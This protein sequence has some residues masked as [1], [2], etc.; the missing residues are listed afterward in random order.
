MTVKKSQTP[1]HVVSGLIDYLSETGQKEVLPEITGKL[2]E[3]VDQSS[4]TNRI[5]VSSFTKL[6][7]EQIAI[8]RQI[9]VGLIDVKLPVINTIDKKL[10]GGF[11]V[12]V[13][14]WFLDASIVKQLQ[15]LKAEII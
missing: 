11:T 8:I 9:I 4:G 15:S 6:T 12:Q 1:D 10:I 5:I 13:G 14:D 2:Q 7:D 3:L